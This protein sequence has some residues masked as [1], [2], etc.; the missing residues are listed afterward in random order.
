MSNFKLKYEAWQIILVVLY[1]LQREP[2]TKVY[3]NML[4]KEL[5]KQLDPMYKYINSLEQQGY[6]TTS[7]KSKY[8]YITLTEK[9]FETV[10]PLCD[11]ITKEIINEYKQGDYF[12]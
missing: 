8:R 1:Y 12:G 9:G 4:A 7:K 3:V 11:L 6:I 2:E 10:Y 5:S